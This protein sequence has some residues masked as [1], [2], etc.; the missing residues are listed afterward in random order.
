MLRSTFH[1]VSLLF[2]AI[3]GVLAQR[4][5]FPSTLN[6]APF[7]PVTS[8]SVCGASQAETYC[9]F[10]A[11]SLASFLPNCIARECNNTCPF[12]DQLPSP[13]DLISLGIFGEEVETTLDGPG[14][15]SNSVF[16]NN[17]FISVPF[18]NVVLQDNGFSFAAWVNLQQN[19]ER[20]VA[21]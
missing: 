3:N 20:Y 5:E 14:S 19:T 11:N 17:S 8:S 21:M 16:I 2:V 10:T 9:L 12:G 1:F 4:G 6:L 7:K 15:N 18:G 13:I